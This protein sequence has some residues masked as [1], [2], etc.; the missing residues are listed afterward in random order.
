MY[1]FSDD[2]TAI[3]PG[4][5][6]RALA[7]YKNLPGMIS[8]TSGMP[9]AEFLP[10]EE[11]AEAFSA[12]MK[13]QGRTALLYGDTAGWYP[14]REQICRRMKAKNQIDATAEQICLTVGGGQGIYTCGR[15]LLNPGDVVLME[16]PSYPGAIQSFQACQA[17]FVEVPTNENGPVIEE[18]EK[19]LATT[20]NIKFM[21]AIPEFQNPSGHTWSL[22]VRRE[23]ME[24]AN[25]YELLVVEDNP[26]G[27][28]RFRGEPIPSLKSMD[29]KGLVIYLGSFSK[30]LSPGL[31]L[32]WICAA[33][34]LL[35]K[36][37]LMVN[38]AVLQA[39]TTT[40]ML[41]SKYLDMYD[42]DRHIERI[43]PVYR[44]RC[45]LM[46]N[47]MRATF[48]EEAVFSDP[49]GGLFT[50]V[51][52]PEHIDTRELSMKGVEKR[53]LFVPGF[54][55]YPTSNRQNCLRLNYSSSTDELIVEGINRLAA[56]IKDAM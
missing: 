40:A 2:V 15:V 1:R 11:L 22:Q 53:V 10:T 47:T 56:V 19:I 16:A 33:P 28:L 5:G 20:K 18:L 7:K 41:I 17:N 3:K 54:G 4:G 42:L 46:L 44:Q 55:F 50:W 29:T 30:I 25:R 26:Y 31:R 23:F 21:Y 48:P 38:T 36:L 9:A 13:D 34:E 37:T 35:E 45:D 12:L 43:I 52:L 32:G 24:L 49:D 8:F 6:V 14:L 27:E 39:S 51:E